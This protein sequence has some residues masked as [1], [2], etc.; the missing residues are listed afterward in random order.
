MKR[1]SKNAEIQSFLRAFLRTHRD[2]Q[3]EKGKKHNKLVS[4]KRDKIPIPKTPSCKRVYQ[5]FIHDLSK[6]LRGI[7]ER[8]SR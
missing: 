7:Y 1:Y 8:K 4:P 2:W 5:N 6:L 3:F